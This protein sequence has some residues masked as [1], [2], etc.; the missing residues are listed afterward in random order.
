MESIVCAPRSLVV[1][2]KI[3]GI[4]ETVGGGGNVDVQNRRKKY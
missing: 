1:G 4:R 3:D 2:R